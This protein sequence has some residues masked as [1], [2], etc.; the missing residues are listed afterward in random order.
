MSYVYIIFYINDFMPSFFWRIL[1][2]NDGLSESAKSCI[3]VFLK[4]K[5]S[6]VLVDRACTNIL[7]IW[8]NRK[9]P[10]ATCPRRVYGSR[11]GIMLTYYK[12][13]PNDN[14]VVFFEKFP[15]S[16]LSQIPTYVI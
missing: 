5:H 11:H 6:F 10:L 4:N 9:V 3:A 1:L 15:N 16:F 2:S 7:A 8:E 13:Q 14:V 12:Q